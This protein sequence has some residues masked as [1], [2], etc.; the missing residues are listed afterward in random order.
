MQGRL[1]LQFRA[2]VNARPCPIFT[3]MTCRIDSPVS[4]ANEY[5]NNT[6]SDRQ[7]RD[8]RPPPGPSRVSPVQASPSTALPRRRRFV[9]REDAK[10]KAR[11]RRGAQSAL[12]RDLIHRRRRRPGAGKR[13][14]ARDRKEPCAFAPSRETLQRARTQSSIV[15][16]SLTRQGKPPLFRNRR[17]I[18]ARVNGREPRRPKTAI[19]PP[20]SSTARSRSRPLDERE[21][22]RRGLRPGDQL[23]LRRAA[24]SRR[25][26]A[27]CP[28][29]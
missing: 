20:V 10:A 21:R 3:F 9:S 27:G 4:N 25:S 23:G 5:R 13:P 11:R 6:V 26:W 15:P 29:W 19:W 28:G 14:S 24:R 7:S 16:L 12:L 17:S 1:V 22:G 18:S 8:C 2:R